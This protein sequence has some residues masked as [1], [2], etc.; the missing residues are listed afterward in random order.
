MAAR[1]F[2]ATFALVVRA[3]LQDPAAAPPLELE[4]SGGG[5]TSLAPGEEAYFELD[6]TPGD[7]ALLCFV[8][9]RDGR[10]H[11]DHGMIRQIRVG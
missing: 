7:Y 9:A 5:I 8:T 3:W 1:H 10:S 2:L 4:G 6:L 11:I